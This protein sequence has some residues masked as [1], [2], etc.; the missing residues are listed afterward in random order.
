MIPQRR[1]KPMASCQTRV[2]LRQ[3]AS[4][5]KRSPFSKSALHKGF[6]TF[7][8]TRKWRIPGVGL[9]LKRHPRERKKKIRNA[10]KYEISGL[11]RSAY[12]LFTDISALSGIVL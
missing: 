9:G 3:V 11:A 2:R 4:E 5:E 6:R 10:F 7:L 12:G 8:R 1:A